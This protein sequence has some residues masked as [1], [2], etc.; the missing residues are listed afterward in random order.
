MVTPR[1][2][3]AGSP[4]VAVAYVRVSTED[5]RLGPDAQRAAIAA[6]AAREGVTVAAWHVDQG[7]SGSTP[8]GDRPGLTAALS[9]L[10]QLGA[11]VLVVAKR[12]RLARDAMVAAM[13]DRLAVTLGA[14][15]ISAD[16][17]GNGDAPAERFMRT[18]VDAAS[19]YE[20]ALIAARTKAGLAVKR[21]RGERV[22]RHAPYGHRFDGDRVVPDA[23]EQAIL[24]RARELRAAGHSLRAVAEELEVLGH[25]NRA[26]KPFAVSNLHAMLASA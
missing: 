5:Q 22:S 19:E 23:A 4:L 8:V 21:A 18:V 20:R 17:A 13:A 12:D 3:R 2:R 25:V 1:R 14:R 6:W 11:G 15:V 16:G 10:A 7:V 9:S 24:S 26:G